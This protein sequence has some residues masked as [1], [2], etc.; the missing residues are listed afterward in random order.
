MTV[1]LSRAVLFAALA[2]LL[3]QPSVARVETPAAPS[4]GAAVA[5]RFDSPLAE[6]EFP[7]LVALRADP[8]WAGALRKGKAL[9]DLARDRANRVAAAT[10][11]TALPACRVDPW[12]WTEADIAT[13]GKALST[14]AGKPGFA[15]S[16]I[17]G[18]LRPSRHF[19][20]HEALEDPAFIA[21]AWADA[22]RGM[23]YVMRVYAAGEAPRYPKIDA[24]IFD[25]AQPDYAYVLAAQ[26][27]VT[28]AQERAD[29]LFF[30]P[31]LRY[32]TT[33]LVTNERDDAASH[34]PLLGGLNA[35][36][37]AALKGIDWTHYPYS[38]L[39]LFGHGPEDAVSR[40]GVMGHLRL[41]LAADRFHRGLAPVI[42]L[43]GGAVHPSR[44]R[45]NEAIEMREELIRHYDVPADRILIDPHARHTTTNLRNVSRLIL[46]TAIPDDKDALILST[47]ETILYIGGTEL[48][49][50][51]KQELG[52]L[53][54]RIGPGPDALSLT[55]RPDALSF[56]IDP[57]DP[58]DP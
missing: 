39:L 20:L 55:F 10:G 30:D 6:L 49:D 58:L 38:A 23:N 12:L 31:A 18:K 45:F 11:C 46:M 13:V 34:R 25:T 4:Q 28:R 17:A 40:T 56:Q 26:E 43:S 15:R 36:T 1:L 5:S 29:D 14:L 50:R 24:I 53:P 57:M 35:A 19:A 51:N 42:I 22:A 9:V 41:R 44:T 48:A 7:L 27:A 47:P 54:G 21:A 2:A 52:Y 3:P 8:V 37:V 32:A 16:L 33:L